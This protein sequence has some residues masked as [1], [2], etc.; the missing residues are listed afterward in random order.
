MILR[1]ILISLPSYRHVRKPTH[2]RLRLSKEDK[3]PPSL[4][5]EQ[6]RSAGVCQPPCSLWERFLCRSGGVSSTTCTQLDQT[7]VPISC[8]LH[9]AAIS[10]GFTLFS[11]L[12]IEFVKHYFSSKSRPKRW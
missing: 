3:L 7:P 5:G 6:L 1:K 4:P 8:S 10:N 2:F 12:L 11:R 9:K